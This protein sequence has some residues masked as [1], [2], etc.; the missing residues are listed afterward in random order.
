MELARAL[1]KDMGVDESRVLQESFGGGVSGDKKTVLSTGPLEIRL[2]RSGLTYHMSSTDTVLES[3]EQN[4][5][6]IPSGCRQGNCGT[7]TTK[8][9]SGNVQ[10]DNE[11][12]LTEE[13]RARGFILPCVSRPLSNL[14]LDA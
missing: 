1:V 3:S 2:S 7:C 11:Q 12:A 9:L 4:G 10:M 5:V 6:L 8:L 13:L 14:V